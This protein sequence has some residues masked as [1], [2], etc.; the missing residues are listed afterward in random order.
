[1]PLLGCHTPVQKDGIDLH[2]PEFSV[3]FLRCKSNSLPRKEGM[4]KGGWAHVQAEIQPAGAGDSEQR[5]YTA[6]YVILVIIHLCCAVTA[7]VRVRGLFSAKISQSTNI[8]WPWH[9]KQATVT[10][11]PG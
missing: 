6:G 2:A 3:E 1:M 8:S 5:P 7:L 11:C 9:T 4:Y 10:T